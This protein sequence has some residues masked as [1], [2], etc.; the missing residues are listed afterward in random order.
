[1]NTSTSITNIAPALLKAQKLIGAAAKDSTN[2]HYRSKF[3]DL[4]SVMAACKAALNECGIVVLQPHVVTERGAFIETVLLHESGEV[5]T[6][7]TPI[8]IARPNDPQAF[9]ASST[10]SR[11]FGLQSFVFIPSE[12]LDGEDAIAQPYKAPKP[13]A[14]DA[15]LAA[16]ALATSGNAAPPT[17]AE[18]P[19]VASASAAA[20]VT[21][22]AAPKKPSSFKRPKSAEVVAPA[23]SQVIVPGSAVQPPTTAVGGGWA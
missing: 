6:S 9:G 21:P 8:I 1:M 14:G 17:A 11:R 4:G 10:Y 2:P 22:D 12:D 16:M 13:A 20:T 18:H 7:Q 5:M 23:V 19:A 15:K 3:A